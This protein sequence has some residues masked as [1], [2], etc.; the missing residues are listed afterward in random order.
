MPWSKSASVKMAKWK[1]RNPS[2]MRLGLDRYVA[3]LCHN[4]R[5]LPVFEGSA[6]SV[7][8]GGFDPDDRSPVMR[9]K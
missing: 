6:G 7:Y 2:S 5:R 9:Y 1:C 8:P 4:F 3:V